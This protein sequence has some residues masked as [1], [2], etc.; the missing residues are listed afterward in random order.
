MVKLEHDYAKTGFTLSVNPAVWVWE[1]S[2]VNNCID[3]KVRHALERLIRKLRVQPNPNSKVCDMREEEIVDIFWSEFEG[4][5][6]QQGEFRNLARFKSNKAWANKSHLL[7]EKYVHQYIKVIE[8]VACR[9]TSKNGGI[10]P[11]ER[12]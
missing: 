4:F 12:G 9:V 1:Y 10:G 5:R 8:Y 3:G 11:C 2:H 6:N 7:H